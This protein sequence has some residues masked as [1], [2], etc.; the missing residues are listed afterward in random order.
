MKEITEDKSGS[1]Y[2]YKN[3]KISGK[4]QQGAIARSI[5]DKNPNNIKNDELSNN[6]YSSNDDTVIIHLDLSSPLYWMF[7]I[8]FLIIQVILVILIGFYYKWD[9]YY[10]NPKSI[11]STSNNSLSDILYSDSSI[12]ITGLD[13]Y[14]SIKNKYRPFQEVNIIIFLGFGLLRAFL[15]HHSWTSIIVTLI[16]GILSLELALF[17]VLCWS[18]L[19]YMNWTY[20]SFNF[21][22]LLD[23]NFCSGAVII[24]LGALLGKLSLPQYI[25][26]ILIETICCSL[27]YTLLRE[28]MKI[29]DIGGALTMHLFGAIFG[30]IFSLISFGTKN[31]QKRI[32]ES[33]HLGANYKSYNFALLGSLILIAYWPSLNT[34][35]INDDFDDDNFSMQRSKYRGVINTYLAIIGSIIST[36]CTS[37]LFN[38]GKFKI[39]DILN[40]CFSGGIVIG[41]CCHLIEHYWLSLIIGFLCGGVTCC[42]YNL[43]SERLQLKG[44]HDTANIFF[45]HAIPGFLGG[46][47]NTIFVGNLSNLLSS[48]DKKIVYK[49]VGTFLNYYYNIDSNSDFDGDVSIPSYAGVHFA[50]IWITLGIAL[51]CG[52]LAG[53]SIKFCNCKIILRYF[54]DYEFFDISESEPFPWSNENV[55]VKLEYKPENY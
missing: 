40:S 4:P 43:L 50:A 26:L 13:V 24:S 2:T 18:S 53:F 11:T 35:L 41:G 34:C 28:V 1:M 49:Y 3:D 14:K 46:I 12:K 52:F 19:F 27:N 55:R 29:I 10:T 38:Q 22:H 30:G 15:K 45:Y 8:V 47:M 21:Q 5:G 44:Y 36:F 6:S 16:G 25:I 7:F 51:A 17:M 48:T 9:D 54:N 33:R 31:E 37:P 42:L 32:R 20:G 39:D 23:A